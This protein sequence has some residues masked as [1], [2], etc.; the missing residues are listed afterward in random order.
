MLYRTTA[1]LILI[2]ALS[3]CSSVYDVR[4]VVIDGKVAF[5]PT[6]T[7]IWGEP[8]CI[9]SISVSAADGPSTNPEEG[10]SLGMVEN[11]MYWHESFAVTSCENPFPVVYGEPLKG[12]PFRENDEY[13][14]KAKPL[15]VGV[16]YE[17]TT[18][19]EGSAS[20]VGKFMVTE[21]RRV[22]NLPYK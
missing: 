2:L 20:G 3:G 19:S 8:D 4:A 21:Q 6:D 17:V 16:V 15:R 18:V 1:A 14:V 11:G 22:V 13:A 7:D 9:Y 10:D 12:P 5:V